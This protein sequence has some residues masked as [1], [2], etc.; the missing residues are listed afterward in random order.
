MIFAQLDTLILILPLLAV[1]A[2]F[3]WRR[4]RS[5][6][7]FSMLPY[8]R[9]RIRPVSRFVHLPKVLELFALLALVLALLDPV[10]LSAE[11]SIVNKGLDILLVLDLSWSMQEPIDLEGALERRRAGIARRE[12]TRLEAV[13]E[14]ML[15][16]VQKRHGD[17]VGLVVFSE[18]AYVVA[19]MT[20]DLAYLTNY[21]RMVD[22][23]TLS[24]EGQTAIGE[25]ILTAL[26]LAEQQKQEG[27]KA[28]SRVMIV[29]TDGENNTGRDVFAAIQKAAE[30]RFKIYFIGVK[31]ERAAETPRIIAAVQTT[32][33]G[34]YDVRDTEQLNRAYAEINRLEKGTYLTKAQVAHVPY[35]HPFA[36][37][38]L[39]LLATSIC[40]RAIPYFIEVS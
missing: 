39:G 10:Q 20:L 5:Y 15:G 3:R 11:R 22:Q 21:L 18:N 23:K 28:L 9:E 13:K 40:L 27:G 36:L 16:F 38:S 12:V 35:Y 26:N 1:F 24:S 17:R 7:T 2:F 25:G 4:Q 14:A 34:Y 29:L 33:G 6:F 19:P 31:V 30:A 8:L 32:G 37:A